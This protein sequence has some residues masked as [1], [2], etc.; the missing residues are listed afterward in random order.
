MTIELMMNRRIDIE[1]WLLSNE[2]R[3]FNGIEE[4]LEEWSTLSAI[5]LAA[6]DAST[7]KTD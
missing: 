5:Q 4:T 2:Q 7:E 6:Y 1:K 3:N